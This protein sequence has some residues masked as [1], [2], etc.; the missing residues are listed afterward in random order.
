MGR[1]KDKRGVEELAVGRD[2]GEGCHRAKQSSLFMEFRN[3]STWRTEQ[4]RPGGGRRRRTMKRQG[5][6]PLYAGTNAGRSTLGGSATSPNK[7]LWRRVGGG[8]PGEKLRQPT[9]RESIDGVGAQIGVEFSVLRNPGT[10]PSAT[11]ELAETGPYRFERIRFGAGDFQ[12]HSVFGT[13]ATSRRRSSYSPARQ[14]IK[15]GYY[16]GGLQHTPSKSYYNVTP[17]RSVSVQRRRFP[18]S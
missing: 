16:Q 2:N 1:L 4:T 6:E 11:A 10:G 7:M 14:N 5:V 3:S 15:V 9:G 13:L 12:H 8:L 18:I 17:F